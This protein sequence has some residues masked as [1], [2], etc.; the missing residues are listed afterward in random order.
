MIPFYLV[1]AHLTADFLLQPQ[2]LLKLKERSLWG[3]AL[4]AC[5]HAALSILF[6]L[7][8]LGEAIVWIS[9]GI[10]TA[11]HA[12]IDHIKLR[13]QSRTARYI[14]PFFIDQIF[15]FI[16]IFAVILGFSLYTRATPEFAPLWLYK[17]YINPFVPVVLEV[18]VFITAVYDIAR[19]QVKLEKNNRSTFHFDVRTNA[20]KL[21]YTA[22]IFFIFA[23][24]SAV[25]GV[26]IS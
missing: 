11:A 21:V 1:L 20:S 22:L 19:F 3:V 7:P 17:M 18:I 6:L 5:I 26:L 25:L 13:V 4:H 14:Y 24:V 10:V 8:F 15:H 9:I 12:I 16:V 23:F 2:S